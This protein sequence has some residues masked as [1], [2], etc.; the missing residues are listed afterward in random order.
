MNILCITH[1]DFETPGVIKDWAVAKNF[2][3]K[4]EKPYQGEIL[5][6]IAGYDLLIIMGGPQSSIEIEKFSYLKDEINLISTAINQNK[7]I[8]GFCL[9]A[10]LTGEALGAKAEKS[11]E[12]EVGVYPITLT[13][14][15]QNDPLFINFDKTFNVI[16]WHNDMPGLTHDSLILA[17]SAACSRQIVKYGKRIYGFQCH[18]EITA[19]DIENMI[20]AVP[21]DLKP[22]KYTQSE[23]ELLKHDY[24]IINNKMIRILNKFIE[25]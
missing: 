19:E 13:E 18:L 2:S 7:R 4:I 12:K 1:A 20:Q 3:F 14:S 16:H 15:G 6:P 11:P 17:S 22:S 21:E 25:L 10:Q 24:S 9:G 8:L 5:S 23:N